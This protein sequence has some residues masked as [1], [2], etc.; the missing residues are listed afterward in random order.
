L[1]APA[2]Q[3]GVEAVL[4]RFWVGPQATLVTTPDHRNHLEFTGAVTTALA[5]PATAGDYQFTVRASGAGALTITASTAA[6]NQPATQTAFGPFPL[7][8]QPADFTFRLQLR[9]GATTNLQFGADGP[10]AK[11][12]LSEV[13]AEKLP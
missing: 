4:P 11:A 7:T 12:R 6:N 1:A 8:E 3:A 9:P 13:K 5:T 2:A 10:D